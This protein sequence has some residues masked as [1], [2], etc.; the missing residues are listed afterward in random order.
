M[1]SAALELQTLDVSYR[2][3]FVIGIIEMFH[4]LKAEAVLITKTEAQQIFRSK[5]K[6]LA[7]TEKEEVESQE[8]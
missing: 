1:I 8:F 7:D 3:I 6:M 4:R 2:R 5:A